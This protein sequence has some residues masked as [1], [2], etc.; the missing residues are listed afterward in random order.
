MRQKQSELLVITKAKDL[1]AYIMTITQKSPKRFRFTFVSRLQ[2][3]SLDI[4]E[5]LTLANDIFVTKE[6]MRDY[7]ERYRLQ[8][9]ALASGKHIPPAETYA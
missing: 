3:Y 9:E 6:D 5:N 8:R 2:N 7:R 4:I 1:C